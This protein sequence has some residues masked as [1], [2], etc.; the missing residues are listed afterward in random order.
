MH[1]DGLNAPHA[2]AN[3]L[4]LL[5]VAERSRRPGQIP[6]TPTPKVPCQR[7]RWPHRNGA[8]AVAHFIRLRRRWSPITHVYHGWR[9]GVEAPWAVTW[10]RSRYAGT[11][12]GATLPG[13]ALPA[14]A[15]RPSHRA[16]ASAHPG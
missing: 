16:G 2:G 12:Q 8:A 10:N 11:N 1:S 7:Q 5:P 6:A 14:Q 9:C 13:P 3:K 4:R 15:R